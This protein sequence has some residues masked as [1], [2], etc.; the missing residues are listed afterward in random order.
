MSPITAAMLIYRNFQPKP[1]VFLSTF[2]PIICHHPQIR[3][4]Q[5]FRSPLNQFPSSHKKS[6][7]QNGRPAELIACLVH[8]IRFIP[9]SLLFQFI[10]PFAWSL[11]PG[12]QWPT[13]GTV[14]KFLAAHPIGQSIFVGILLPVFGQFHRRCWRWWWPHWPPFIHRPHSP[15]WGH[16]GH[17]FAFTAAATFRNRPFPQF[18]WWWPPI[19]ISHFASNVSA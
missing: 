17:S 2:R 9:F 19:S 15:P 10:V 3:C 5:L 6:L 7:Q 12:Q 13:V 1:N 4:H 8:H 14:P 18:W 16:H 11:L